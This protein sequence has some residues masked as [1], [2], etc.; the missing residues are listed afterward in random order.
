M[1]DKGDQKVI[2]VMVMIMIVFMGGGSGD[3]DEVTGERGCGGGTGE[4]LPWSTGHSGCDLLWLL[5]IQQMVLWIL[6]M[7]Q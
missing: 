7:Q 3:G 4:C 1:R 5:R 6:S 2:M